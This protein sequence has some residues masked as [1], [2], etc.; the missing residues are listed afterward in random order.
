MEKIELEIALAVA[1]ANMIG[2]TTGKCTDSV[3]F[4]RDNAIRNIQ[5]IVRQLLRKA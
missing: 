2:C 4:A 1:A 5:R 3:I